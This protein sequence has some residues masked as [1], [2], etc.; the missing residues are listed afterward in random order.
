[1]N[2]LCTSAQ[3]IKCRCPAVGIDWES[4]ERFKMYG[5]VKRT[6]PRGERSVASRDKPPSLMQDIVALLIKIFVILTVLVL[7]FTFLFGFTTMQDISM[8][9]AVQPSDIVIY[10][11]LGKTCV[12]SETV[13]LEYEGQ[14]Q[15]RRVVAIEGDTVD[16]TEE[17]LFINGAYMAGQNTQ[18]ILLHTNGIT[19]PVTVPEG[20]VFLLADHR[21]SGADSR[22]YGTVAI[23]DLQGKV[24]TII[25][26]R[27][28]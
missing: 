18:E 8:Q 1:M 24:I 6:E 22:V 19:F 5:A 25:R 26:H 20:H 23:K 13:V 3:G 17:G 11:R 4:R 12:A 15:V 14:Q 2:I 9:P 16:I 21:S 27:D 7:L 28:I 10:Y